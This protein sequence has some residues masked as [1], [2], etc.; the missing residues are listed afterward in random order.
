MSEAIW[1]LE[2]AIGVPLVAVMRAPGLLRALDAATK[3]CGNV[4]K[5]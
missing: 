5:D 4:I 3:G 2:D 1:R